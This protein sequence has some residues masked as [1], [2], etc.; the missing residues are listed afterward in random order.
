MGSSSVFRPIWTLKGINY[1]S[2]QRIIDCWSVYVYVALSWWS[3]YWWPFYVQRSTFHGLQMLS[4]TERGTIRS[5]MCYIVYGKLWFKLIRYVEWL[6][7]TTWL[8]FRFRHVLSRL[9]STL[10]TF[11]VYSWV[12]HGHQS[13]QTIIIVLA[14]VWL[15]SK[16]TLT[17][18]VM[19]STGPLCMSQR[20]RR[21]SRT[22]TG[23]FPFSFGQIQWHHAVRH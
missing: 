10:V 9:C 3:F 12:K 15:C 5:G 8:E 14:N 6:F 2:V 18:I 11:L 23:A 20:K 19:T 7:V 4:C 22:G 16:Q 17:W 13:M 21:R 1:I